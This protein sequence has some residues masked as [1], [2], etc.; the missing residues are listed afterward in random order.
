MTDTNRAPDWRRAEDY[1]YI[2]ALG[3][4][5]QRWEVLRRTPLYRRMWAKRGREDRGGCGL[6]LMIDPAKSA[7]EAAP[8]EFLDWSLQGGSIFKAMVPVDAASWITAG[9]DRQGDYA[10][11]HYGRQLMDLADDGYLILAFDPQAPRK[12]Q[13][14][15]ARLAIEAALASFDLGPR[16]GRVNSSP[17]S[18]NRGDP[19]HDQKVSTLARVLDAYNKH[20]LPGHPTP[21]FE[22]G[23]KAKIGRKLFADDEGALE[24]TRAGNNADRAYKQALAFARRPRPAEIVGVQ[25]ETEE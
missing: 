19:A 10:A 5:E 15:R 25:S 8:I 17:R 2:D 4:A 23:V 9:R 12:P 14:A 18:K 16:E 7:I 21:T 13:L 22:R 1:E 6:R 11:L 3:P 24:E 20:S